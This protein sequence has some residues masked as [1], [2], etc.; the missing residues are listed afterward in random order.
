[1]AYRRRRRIRRIEYRDPWSGLIG[2]VE[3]DDNQ[4]ATFVALVLP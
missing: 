3:V 1:V 4:R 2:I